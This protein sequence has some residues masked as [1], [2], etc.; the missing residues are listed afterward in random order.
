MNIY[1]FDPKIEHVLLVLIG[2]II[3]MAI[4][5]INAVLTA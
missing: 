2:F 1:E 5:F 3:L 4:V